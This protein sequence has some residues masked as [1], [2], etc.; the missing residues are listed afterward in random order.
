[1]HA[2]KQKKYQYKIFLSI[3]S[4]KFERIWMYASWWLVIK[5]NQSNTC[6]TNDMCWLVTSVVTLIGF[7]YCKYICNAHDWFRSPKS[8]NRSVVGRGNWATLIMSLVQVGPSCFYYTRQSKPK[9]PAFLI[10]H[11]K[12]YRVLL[13]WY[14]GL[15]IQC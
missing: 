1:M 2:Y 11:D 9:T 13:L 5:L 4:L 3:K 10:S 14:V 8:D 7:R 15:L 12:K 6:N